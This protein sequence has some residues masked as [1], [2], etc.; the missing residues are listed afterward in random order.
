MIQQWCEANGVEL[1]KKLSRGGAS[2]IS[3][4]EKNDGESG[5]RALVL[6]LRERLQHGEIET[7]RSAAEELRR[8]AK[9]SNGNRVCIAEAGVIPILVALLR[10]ADQK[11]QEHA[12]TALLNLSINDHNKGLIVSSG[13][14]ESIVHVLEKGSTEAKENAAATLFSLSVIDENKISI[15]QT[16]AIPALVDLLQNGTQRGKKDAA[17]ALFN[18]SIYSGNKARAVR[19]GVVPPLMELLKNRSGGMTDESLAILA[20]LA[21]SLEGRNSIGQAHAVPV[22]V[23]LISVGSARNKENA[24]S[25]L[26]SLCLNGTNHTEEAIKLNAKGPLTTLLRHGTPRAKRKASQLLQHIHDHESQ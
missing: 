26:L 15:G 8:L 13:A 4:Q 12:V 18:L 16:G 22:L 17:T 23:D 19:A 3:V 1:P 14:I 24:A 11:I 6:S 25:V 5:D 7:R 9:R 10:A 21:T 20:I 2:R